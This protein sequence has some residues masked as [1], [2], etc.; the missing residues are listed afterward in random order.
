MK[1]V[2]VVVDTRNIMT[3]LNK[4]YG[5]G[6]LNYG[7]YLRQAVPSEDVLYRGIAYIAQTEE[8]ASKFS[9]FLYHLG[10]ESRFRPP[11]KK[12]QRGPDDEPAYQAVELDVMLAVDVM[13]IASTNKVDKLVIGSSS[14]SLEDLISVI[15]RDYGI[16]TTVF[17]CG[18]PRNLRWAADESIEIP[19]EL[20]YTV[21]KE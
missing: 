16:H 3:C 2:M 5:N 7:E 12:F 20:L 11:V 6:R 15:K 19:K 13:K 21:E 18:I 9:S 10:F 4:C 1:N 14:R 8:Q 17:A